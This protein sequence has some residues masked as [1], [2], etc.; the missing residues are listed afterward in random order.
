MTTMTTHQ[1]AT[2]ADIRTDVEMALLLAANAPHGLV[3][4][5]VRTRLSQH[6]A[7]L[8]EPAGKYI[9]GLEPTHTR[10]VAEDTL[11]YAR[12]LRAQ[13]E[14]DPAIR[15]RLLAKAAT[16]LLRYAQATEEGR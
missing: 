1:P 4:T 10:D 5:A 16:F 15:L 7:D 9:A 8:D 2:A 12:T 3:A 13:T 11:R 6:L 14:G